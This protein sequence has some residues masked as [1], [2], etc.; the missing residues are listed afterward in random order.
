VTPESTHV[1]TAFSALS[2][3]DVLSAEQLSGGSSNSSWLVTTPKGR[4]AVRLY[5][6][7]DI[8]A[9]SQVELLRYLAGQS[10]PVPEV[11]FVG[12]HEAHHLLALSWVEGSTAVEALLARPDEA[13]GFGRAFGEA[14]ARLHAVPVTSEMRAALQAV[15]PE[16]PASIG[17][18][19]HLDCHL[20]NVMMSEK[21][22]VVSVI[23][24]ENVRL[25]DARYDVART[26]SI[27]CADPSI[28]ALPGALRQV[29]RR[30]RK[31]Y[32]RGYEQ[33][34]GAEAL[35]RLEPFLAWSGH[36]M[37]RDFE[38]RLDARGRASITRWT[39][40]WQARAER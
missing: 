39:R 4:Y 34:A 6:Y 7:S 25:G 14:H 28:R 12:T 18:L 29:V 33:A 9:Y 8:A 21:G 23:D 40:W 20:L 38:G 5:P 13:E 36:F 27:L 31:G 11:A 35:A 1:A 15:T 2:G 32:L 37:L 17:V 30:F 22:L 19:I 16:P 24:W 26:L 10:Y 3:T